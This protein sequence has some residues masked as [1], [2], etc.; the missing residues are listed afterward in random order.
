MYAGHIARLCWHGF[1][2]EIL[3]DVKRRYVPTNENPA[4]CASRG[5]RSRY[6]MWFYGPPFLLKDPNEWPETLKDVKTKG[7][8]IEQQV[9]RPATVSDDIIA[10]LN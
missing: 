1:I 4:G 5:I 6:Q 10:I 9:S 8:R 3:P 2:Y 7:L